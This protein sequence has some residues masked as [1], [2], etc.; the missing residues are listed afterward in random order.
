MRTLIST[1]ALVLFMTA[2][3]SAAAVKI[4]NATPYQID[5]VYISPAAAE[6]WGYDRLGKKK[7]IA[8]GEIWLFTFIGGNYC[9]WDLR[10][11]FHNGRHRTIRRQDICAYANPIWRI[12][13]I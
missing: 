6:R 3:A 1:I 11:T 13:Y 2:V 9:V 10:V 7:F 12:T 8:P 4:Q 5:R